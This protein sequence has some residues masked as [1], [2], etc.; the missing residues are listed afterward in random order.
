MNDSN[1]IT[2]EIL[3]QK[4]NRFFYCYSPKLRRFLTDSGVNWTDR[5]INETSGHPFWVF[6]KDSRLDVALKEYNKK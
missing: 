6:A 1:A 5:G 3:M 2:G 4:Q